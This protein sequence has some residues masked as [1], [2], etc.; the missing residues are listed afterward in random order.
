MHKDLKKFVI[1]YAD[2]ASSALACFYDAK[3]PSTFRFSLLNFE[4]KDGK[5]VNNDLKRQSFMLG[6]GLKN[7]TAIL[8]LKKL[9]QDSIKKSQA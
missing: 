1:E 2:G 7:K 6:T 9:H 4:L 3:D 5:L 8:Q